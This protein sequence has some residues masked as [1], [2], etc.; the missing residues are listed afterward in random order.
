M[1]FRGWGPEAIE[2]YEGLEA[3]NSKTYWQANKAVYEEKVLAP[4]QVLLEELAPEFGGGHIFR[5]YRDVRFSANKSPYKTQVAATLEKGGYISLGAN[6]LGAGAGYYMLMSDQLE[7]YR[8][9][10][11]DEKTGTEIA[12]LVA[13]CQE[14]GDR[15]LGARRPEDDPSRVPEGPPP[16][17]PA[18]AEGPHHVEGLAGRQV[19]RDVRMQGQGEA[20]LPRLAAGLLLARRQRRPDDDGAARARSLTERTSGRFR[21]AGRSPS[22]RAAC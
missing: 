18:P 2:F 5:P 7:R 21:T 15:G 11:D 19:A 3:D 13:C 9:A 22:G 4:M 8:Q 6:G 12:G 10:V 1:G 17:R 14:E 20:V 16:R